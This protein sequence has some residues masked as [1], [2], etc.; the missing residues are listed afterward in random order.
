MAITKNRQSFKSFNN[1]NTGKNKNE[2]NFWEVKNTSKQNSKVPLNTN[3]SFKNLKSS[4]P[5][6][7]LYSVSQNT[8]NSKLTKNY[9]QKYVYRERLDKLNNK[10][11]SDT[12][13]NKFTKKSDELLSK[14][15]NSALQ[16]SHTRH[17]NVTLRNNNS[18]RLFT[19]DNYDR[20]DGFYNSRL[21]SYQSKTIK[22]TKY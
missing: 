17:N 13:F 2:E 22:Y 7:G 5:L 20:T 3:T 8:S 18:N 15:S 1:S 4:D 11:F 21:P 16:N 19:E 10:L 14:R 9:N 12:K 6:S